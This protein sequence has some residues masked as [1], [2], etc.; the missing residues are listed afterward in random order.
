MLAMFTILPYFRDFICGTTARTEPYTVGVDAVDL[1][2]LFKRQFFDGA[3]N[4]DSRVV[5]ENVNLSEL[6]EC[7]IDHRLRRLLGRRIRRDGDGLA[8]VVA[9]DLHC[10]S[11][12]LVDVAARQQ[13][14]RAS[15]RQALGHGLAQA[16]GTARH[17]R[18]LSG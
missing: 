6:D 2:E 9:L 8:A 13:Q 3:A 11:V 17:D 5:D 15:R 1:S 10:D 4:V 7:P 14:V 16:F 12:C 18:G